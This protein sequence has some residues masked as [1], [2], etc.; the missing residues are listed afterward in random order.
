MVRSQSPRGSRILWNPI[1]QRGGWCSARP[2]LS[3]TEA[4]GPQ[5]TC[6]R[7]N[8]NCFGYT[9]RVLNHGHRSRA[10]TKFVPNLA[11]HSALR[12]PQRPIRPC[13]TS[14]PVTW[15]PTVSRR[16]RARWWVDCRRNPRT[17]SDERRRFIEGLDSLANT[18]T[19]SGDQTA[20][21]PREVD[22]LSQGR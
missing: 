9:V 16:K 11:L 12:W 13:L 15:A 6:A 2:T 1:K 5:R 18:D 4:A 14:T 8:I 7:A 3:G 20:H 21:P 22:A 19:S 17:L 10:H